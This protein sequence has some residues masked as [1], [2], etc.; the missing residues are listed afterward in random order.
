MAQAW[1]VVLGAFLA[2]ITS[3]AVEFAKIRMQKDWA[4][5]LLRSLV[6]SRITVIPIVFAVS[7]LQFPRTTA[8][9]SRWEWL[10]RF[11]Q[12]I[13]PRWPWGDLVYFALIILFSYFYT[14]RSIGSERRV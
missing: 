1:L 10:E 2:V 7:V 11:A 6:R 8:E 14:R 9:F 5:H 3:L 4:R 12:K 13:L